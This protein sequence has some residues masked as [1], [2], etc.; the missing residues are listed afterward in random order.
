ML[1]CIL[2]VGGYFSKR[3]S[4][5]AR[6]GDNCDFCSYMEMDKF[7]S[8]CING[9]I[10]GNRQW[11]F[12]LVM[13]II[14]AAILIFTTILLCLV[15]A[16][17]TVHSAIRIVLANILI[18]SI[19][20]CLGIALICLR[21][22]IAINS[23]PSSRPDVSFK[24]FL[25][26]TAIGG[27]GR[28]AFMAVFAVVVVVIIKCSNS[29][30]KLKYL[31]ISVM[32]VWTACVALGAT[33]V[34]PGVVDLSQCL[35]DVIF[36]AGVKLWVFAV[37]YFLFFV[38]IP[39]ILATVLPV[40][41]FCYIRSNLVSENA[42]SLKPMLKFTL[43]LLLG[44]GLGFFGNSLATAGILISGNANANEDMLLELMRLYH[45]SLALSLIPTPILILVYFKP[46]RVKL[47]KC[48]LRVCGKLCRSHLPS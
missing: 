14:D 29:A 12:C 16:A 20:A 8:L 44:N 46:V 18:A 2:Q 47:K 1:V 35:A 40:Y 41:A 19:A 48:V 3:A 38:I 11:N 25:A 10:T 7:I 27:N 30:V 37:P 9:T 17:N 45:V 21:A 33:L 34:V 42:S 23:H 6:L 43:F 32:V 15:V 31:I 28:S 13:V 4:F 39:C 22:T 26:I 5:Q 24:I 36:L